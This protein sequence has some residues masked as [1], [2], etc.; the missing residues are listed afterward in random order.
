M[1]LGEARVMVLTPKGD[2]L[3]SSLGQ[4]ASRLCSPDY[5]TQ[6]D[7][8]SMAISCISQKRIGFCEWDSIQKRAR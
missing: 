6:V 5:I 8:S 7:C 3:L 1:G 2:I 4:I